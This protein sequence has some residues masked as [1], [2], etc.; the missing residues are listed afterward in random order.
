[1]LGIVDWGIGG[2]DFFRRLR[3]RHP[4]VPIVY[5]SDTGAT[6]YGKLPRTELLRR[7]ERVIA[8]LRQRGVTQ[9]VVACNAAS[10]VLPSLASALPVRGVVE[11]GIRAALATPA[12]TIGVIGGLRTIRSGCYRRA[13]EENGRI[14][15]QRIAQPLSARVESGDLASPAL[16]HEIARIVS[17]LRNVDALVLAC[18]HYLALAARFRE[19]L[20]GVLLI[21]PV[22]ELLRSISSKGTLPRGSGETLFLTSGDARAMRHAAKMAFDV[23]LPD[24]RHVAI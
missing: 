18:T 14:V 16:R 23:T 24:A 1:M 6:P 15:R 5:F 10:T 17:P 20:P 12:T 4:K 7:L 3:A 19:T 21:D 8:E 22:T 2:V 13:L 11:H 9:I